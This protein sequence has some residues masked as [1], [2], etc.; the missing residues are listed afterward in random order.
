MPKPKKVTSAMSDEKK[1]L[2]YEYS[3]VGLYSVRSTE[4]D[5]NNAFTTYRPNAIKSYRYSMERHNCITL[6]RA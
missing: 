4:S 3:K 2:L 6:K 1:M 5:K